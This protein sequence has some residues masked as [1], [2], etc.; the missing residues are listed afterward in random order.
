MT[1]S[2]RDIIRDLLNDD[3]RRAPASAPTVSPDTVT[4][5]APVE[6][7]S[8]DVRQAERLAF[9]QCKRT[10]TKWWPG[11]WLY[12]E[13][14]L[15]AA[16]TLK[17]A[18]IPASISLFAYA[19]SGAGKN[20]I[21][22]MFDW[23]LERL[24]IWRDKFTLAA[25]QSAHE[26]TDPKTLNDRAMFRRVK[27]KL[28]VTPELALLFRGRS[29]ELERRFSELA[30]LLDGEGRIVDSG[31]HGALGEK[32][33]FTTVWVGGTTPFHLTTW[34][35]MAALGT[36][37]LF[38]RIEKSSYVDDELFAQ[39]LKEC[40][41]AVSTFLDVLIPEGS[42]RTASWPSMDDATKHRLRQYAALMALGHG[43]R[44]NLQGDPEPEF[45]TPN[46]FRSRLGYLVRGR[47]LV[48]GRD[49]VTE[50]D[51][52]MARWIT[53]SSMPLQRGPVLLELFEGTREITAI[54][55]RT[56]LS[57]NTVSDT[58]ETLKKLKVVDELGTGAL[59]RAGKP[60]M[61]YGISDA[62]LVAML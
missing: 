3:T 42:A 32:G 7:M 49:S 8:D 11:Y 46:H 24:V 25:L 39:A 59:D 60:P 6:A 58:I 22:K 4:A 35:T 34:N 52:T 44:Q 53:L 17:L 45:P 18:N 62:A 55:A 15:S 29:D 47:A 1:R 23:E 16:A 30:Q 31:T 21:F 50:D 27:H 20:T 12:V 56:G 40:K 54:A 41:S 38:F 9:E 43:K 10:V 14:V 51:L 13:A 26:A 36:R 28:F 57:I 48:Y 37:L 19:P 33:D 2:V 5:K 61:R